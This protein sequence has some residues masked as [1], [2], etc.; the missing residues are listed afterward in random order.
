LCFAY[1][2]LNSGIEVIHG[3]VDHLMTKFGLKNGDKTNG[4]YIEASDEKT[5]FPDRQANIYVQGRKCGTFGI[6]HPKILKNFG[7]KNPVSLCDI[8][9]EYIFEL[10]YTQKILM[11]V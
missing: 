10:I 11:A 1:S 6:V 3:I 4:Y 7:I 5:F 2:N 9:I 8:D